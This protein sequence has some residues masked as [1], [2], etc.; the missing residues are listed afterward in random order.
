MILS[1]ST[2]ACY[3]ASD[4]CN[5]QTRVALRRSILSVDGVQYTVRCIAFASRAA[6]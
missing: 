3:T 4:A 1:K 6:L 5:G 2:S